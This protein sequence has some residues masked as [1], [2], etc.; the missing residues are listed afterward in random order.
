MSRKMGTID[1]EAKSWIENRLRMYSVA[2]DSIAQGQM[3]TAAW[4]LTVLLK[5]SE[6]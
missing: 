3:I 5:K 6:I 2:W 4:P 1:P